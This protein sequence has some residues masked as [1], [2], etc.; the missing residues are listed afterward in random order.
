V[1]VFT[2]HPN[3]IN[4][5]FDDQHHLDNCPKYHEEKDQI[6]LEDFDDLI[7]KMQNN[8]DASRFITEPDDILGYFGYMESCINAP[9][10]QDWKKAL[11]RIVA[12]GDRPR[13]LLNLMH[14]PK[15]V[16]NGG[17][18]TT[19]SGIAKAIGPEASLLGLLYTLTL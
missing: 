9:L 14:C 18:K 5:F 13:A 16:S 12:L 4:I 3:G 10:P 1:L 8:L 6:S 15:D 19:C 11:L 2:G 17:Q 7:E